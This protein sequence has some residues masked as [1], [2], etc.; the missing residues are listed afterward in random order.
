MAKNILTLLTTAYTFPPAALEAAQS[1]RDCVEA[2]LTT[3]TFTSHT[4]FPLTEE[5]AMVRPLLTMPP[6]PP[7][8]SHQNSTARPPSTPRVDARTVGTK[9]QCHRTLPDNGAGQDT[10]RPP[11][12][13]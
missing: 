6:V 11:G 9:T 1:L 2:A 10:N 12:P 8:L 7:A 13:P 5:G 3:A 4:N